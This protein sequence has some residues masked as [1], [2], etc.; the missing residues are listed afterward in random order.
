M[1]DAKGDTVENVILNHNF[2]RGLDSWH[3]NGCEAYVVPSESG[4]AKGMPMN[5]CGGYAVVTKRKE[6]WHG[7]EQDITSRITTGSV[8]KVSA[9]VGVSSCEGPANVVATLKL[10]YKR[11]DTQFLFIQR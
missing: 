2:C 7:L 10:E 8:Y 5:L 1:S 6:C 9:L 3:P 4:N 11:S